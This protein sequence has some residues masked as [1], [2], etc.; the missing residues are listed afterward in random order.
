MRRCVTCGRPF[1]TVE[2]IA[3]AGTT[4]TVEGPLA[5][6]DPGTVRVPGATR[7]EDDLASPFPGASGVQLGSDN[8][9]FNYSYD[10]RKDRL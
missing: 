9:Q 5:G 6:T 1:S 7:G 3:H 8:V 2:R 4:D 10:N